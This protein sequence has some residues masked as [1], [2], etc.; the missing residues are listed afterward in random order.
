MQERPLLSSHFRLADR[1]FVFSRASLFSDH[2][3]LKGWGIGGFFESK[4]LLS[5]IENVE[6]WTGDIICN[7]EI[8]TKT[9]THIRLWIKS[10]AQWKFAILEQTSTN[11]NFIARI[12]G[13]ESSAK[14]AA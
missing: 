3:V 4:I 13:L 11:V 2:I 7:L 1:M 14:A 9:G 5:E 10:A 12:P 6:W 8:V